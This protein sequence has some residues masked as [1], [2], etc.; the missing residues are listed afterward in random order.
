MHWITIEKL[1]FNLDRIVAFKWVDEKLCIYDGT[2]ES[3][4]ISD[5]DK[6]YYCKLC[7]SCCMSMV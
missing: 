1:H 3:F 2:N 6:R 7:N 4:Y 5:P